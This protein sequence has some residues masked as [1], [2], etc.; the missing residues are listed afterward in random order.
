MTQQAALWHGAACGEPNIYR[1]DCI[2]W[3]VK[4]LVQNKLYYVQR[5]LVTATC[6][7]RYFRVAS[8]TSHKIHTDSLAKVWPKN[9]RTLYK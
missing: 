8:E 2:L 3:A 1:L 4:P 5:Q 7:I 6:F 9:Y